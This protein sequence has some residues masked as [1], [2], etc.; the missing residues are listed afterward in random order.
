LSLID[1]GTG[2]RSGRRDILPSFFVVALVGIA[3]QEM[4][5]AVRDSVRA[6]GFSLGTIVLMVIFFLTA[7]RFFVGNQLH[8]QSDRMQVIKGSVWFIDLMVIVLESTL[9]LFLGGLSSLE[10]S[11]ASPVGFFWLLTVLYLVDVVWIFWQWVMHRLS[12]A[13]KREFI[14][15]PWAALNAFLAMVMLAIYWSSGNF[16]SR[17]A[18]IILGLLNVAGFV[19]DMVLVD[20]YKMLD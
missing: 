19:F 4:V 14:P 1:G 2:K 5:G 10:A 8:L 15:W 9:L 6:H 11:L 13:W 20:N 12:P 16:Y 17:N 18:L 7:M 3:Y